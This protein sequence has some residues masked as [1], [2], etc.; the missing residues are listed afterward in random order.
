MDL[1]LIAGN[2]K[3]AEL[4]SKRLPEKGLTVQRFEKGMRLARQNQHTVALH[5]G[6]GRQLPDLVEFCAE[7]N[8]PVLQGSTG[9]KLDPA[10][11]VLLVDAPNFALPILRLIHLLS[12]FSHELTPPDYT[13]G[14]SV[15][16]SHQSTK[17]SFPATAAR[18]AEAV[19]ALEEDV[20]SIR[21]QPTQLALGVPFEALDGHGYHWITWA[22][23]G[24]VIQ[25]STKVNGRDAYF[26]G[27][28]YL[29]RQ[30]HERREEKGV[31]DVLKFLGWE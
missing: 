24:V 19:G 20:I 18:M 23:A 3:M 28:H 6:T 14:I 2:G 21:D 31:Q 17:R 5:M 16:E 7:R 22:G 25:L 15:M 27:G 9:Q 29:L 10:W 13:L 26:G 12:N 11:P 8:I 30:L 4:F 1:I